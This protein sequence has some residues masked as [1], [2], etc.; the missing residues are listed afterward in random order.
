MTSQEFALWMRGVCDALGDEPPTPERWKRICEQ[1]ARTETKLPQLS[2]PSILDRFPPS[3]PRGQFERT[4]W[5]PNGPVLPFQT[6]QTGDAP[7]VP[8]FVVTCAADKDAERARLL[9]NN[10][11]VA[12]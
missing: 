3:H 4:K 11:T 5:Y 10:Q 8:P 2:S 1:V 9:A 6:P 12:S 7:W